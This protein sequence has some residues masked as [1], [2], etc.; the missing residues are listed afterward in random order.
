MTDRSRQIVSRRQLFGIG[1][2]RRRRRPCRLRYRQ[3]RRARGKRFREVRRHADHGHRLAA[4]HARPRRDRAGPDPA[5]EHGNVRPARLV[6]AHRDGG[7]KFVP[8]LAESYTVSPDA[9]VY[10][11]K[12]R[13]ASPSTMHEVRRVGGQGTYDHIVDPA[14][15][16]KSGLGAWDRTRDEDHRP[17]YGPDRLHRAER[18]VH[19]PAGAG[20]S[21]SRRR[22]RWPSTAR[23]GSATIRSAPA[24]S[25]S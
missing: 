11:F 25:S 22:P 16:S 17:I 4:R 24:R 7:S 15:K 18:R 8:G 20:T 1:P 23:R 13:K 14:T 5:D 9:S 10:T 3:R 12:L 2:R 6:A 19:A 21:A